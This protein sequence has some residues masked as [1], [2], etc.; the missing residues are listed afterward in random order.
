VCRGGRLRLGG[1]AATAMAR[2]AV[3]RE[4]VPRLRRVQPGKGRGSIGRSSR[5]GGRRPPAMSGDEAVATPR[6]R[7]PARARTP[8]RGGGGMRPSARG[9]GDA[10]TGASGSGGEEMAGG[11]GGRRERRA[12]TLPGAV[13]QAEKRRLAAGMVEP[14]REGRMSLPGTVARKQGTVDGLAGGRSRRRL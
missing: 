2:E 5:S 1:M 9:S 3:V 10:D 14:P 4:R 12:S 6:A 8:S 13:H 7:R 11:G